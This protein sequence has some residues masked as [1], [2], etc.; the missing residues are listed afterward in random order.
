MK[1]FRLIISIEGKIKNRNIVMINFIYE[2]DIILNY[3]GREFE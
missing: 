1:D 3:F 2:F